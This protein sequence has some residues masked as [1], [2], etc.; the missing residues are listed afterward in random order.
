MSCG[1][2]EAKEEGEDEQED[3]RGLLLLPSTA[4]MDAHLDA[5]PLPKLTRIFM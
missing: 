2:R 3:Q 1:D 5:M 4:T